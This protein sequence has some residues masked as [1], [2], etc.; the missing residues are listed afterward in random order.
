MTV[1]C[2]F[3]RDDL[4]RLR[5]ALPASVERRGPRTT[6]ELRSFVARERATHGV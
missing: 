5:L 2:T 3:T 6:T 1:P 4:E